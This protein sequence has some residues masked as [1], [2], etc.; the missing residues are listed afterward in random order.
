MKTIFWVEDRYHWIDKFKPIF[1]SASFEGID[2]AEQTPVPLN[3]VLVHKFVESASQAI[4]RSGNQP[5]IVILDADMNGD[6]NAGLC[7]SQ[8][9]AKKWPTVPVIFLSEHSGTGI[10]ERVFEQGNSSDFIAKHQQNVEQVICWRIKAL[11]RQKSLQ[12]PHATT[13]SIDTLVSGAL[14]IDLETWNVYWHKRRLMNPS[15]NLRPLA[16]TPR[17]ILRLL[18]ESSPRPVTTLQMEEK[19]ESDKFNYA[20]Y[21]QHIKTLRHSFESISKEINHDS[22]LEYC[23]NGKGIVTFGEQGAY[24]WV[25]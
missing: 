21:R 20:C 4:N 13:N 12:T 24:C 5:D 6:Q 9:I 2:I 19:L 3:K 22:F 7:L 15:N 23:K 1:E 14:L 18:V 8:L 11:L 17:K 25:K 16:P 10:E